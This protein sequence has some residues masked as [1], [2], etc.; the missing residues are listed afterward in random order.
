MHRPRLISARGLALAVSVLALLGITAPVFAQDETSSTTAPTAAPVIG[1]TN[2]WDVCNET[3]FA[4]R[5]A[6]AYQRSGKM[7]T[8]GWTQVLPGA[9]VSLDTPK[10]SPRFLFA[11][12]LPVHRGGIREWKGEVELCAAEENFVSESSGDCRLKNLRSRDFFAVKPTERQTAFIEPA[13]YGTNA[14]IAGLQRLLQDA[15]YDVS[16]VDGRTGRRT[17]RAIIQAKS[18]LELESDV[19]NAALLKALLPAAKAKQTEIGL[20]ICNKSTAPIWTAIA[21]RTEGEWASRGW[22][23]I[24]PGNCAKP[25][26]E[27]LSGTEAHIFA[28]QAAG[29]SEDGDTPDRRL[30]AVGITPAQF[31]IAESKFAALGRE[32]CTELGYS[33]A[34]FRP[35][36]TDRDGLSIALLDTDFSAPG[37]DGLRR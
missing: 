19:S 31:C 7:Q 22:W 12:S 35:V 21:H 36:P 3:S 27:P 1:E 14:E 9:C 13:D 16:R 32:L 24:T 17:S 29:P 18:D 2:N 26:D 23:P 11:E 37:N 25:M 28:L 15:G 6:T 34:N 33:I 5:Y 4:L 20:E 8:V 10:I 30:R